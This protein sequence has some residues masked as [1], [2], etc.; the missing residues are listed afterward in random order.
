MASMAQKF[1]EYLK[2]QLVNPKDPDDIRVV[3]FNEIISLLPQVHSDRY[4]VFSELMSLKIGIESLYILYRDEVEA[5]KMRVKECESRLVELYSYNDSRNPLFGEKKLTKQIIESAVQGDSEYQ[6][7]LEEQ[8]MAENYRSY[9]MI[10]RDAVKDIL[11]VAKSILED[12][13]GGVSA[14]D[15][16]G[17]QEL[18]E[19]ANMISS[20]Q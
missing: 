12:P 11:S 8:K 16:E 5:A 10:V 2:F 20:G 9:A 1:E 19:I 17:S 14:N 6:N 7:L 13:F 3:D 4:K 18:E 15:R